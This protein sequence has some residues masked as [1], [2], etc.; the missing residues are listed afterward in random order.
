MLSEEVT[1]KI[2]DA[3]GK[4]K[5]AAG[6][7]AE[8]KGKLD[9]YNVF[10]QGLVAYTSGVSEVTNGASG[11]KDG[12]LQLQEGSNEINEGMK[13]LTAGTGKFVDETDGM[14]KEVSDEIDSLISTMAGSNI[15][16]VSFVSEYNSEVKAVQFVIKTDAIKIE[17]V[18]TVEVEAKESLNFWQKL[19][20]LFGLY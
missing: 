20:R 3:V 17:E 6:K 13:E 2:A 1:Q 12:I 15:E 19:L 5:E 11:L 14:D 4:V 9:N 10:Y 7:V 16:T 18:E 8:L